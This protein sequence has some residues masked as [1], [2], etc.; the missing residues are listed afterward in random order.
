MNEHVLILGAALNAAVAMEFLSQR[1]GAADVLADHAD[2][3][4][5][6]AES[7]PTEL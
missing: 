3:L 4:A 7:A 5:D 1:R 2:A 6:C